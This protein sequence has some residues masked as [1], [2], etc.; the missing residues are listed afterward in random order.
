MFGLVK[1]V[2]IESFSFDESLATKSKA[3][4][5][6]VCMIR[7]TLIDLNPVEHNYYPFIISLNK[8]SG[9]CNAADDLSTKI[10]VPSKIKDVN[11]KV[12]NITTGMILCDFKCKLNST[13]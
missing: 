2:F 1:Q 7:P 9:S 6:K 4:N 3:L 10:C 5:N 8:G 12:Y 11:V 13:T